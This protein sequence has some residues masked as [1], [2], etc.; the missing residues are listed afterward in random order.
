MSETRSRVLLADDHPMVLEGLRK[1]L[2]PDFE[3]V[4]VVTD[5]HELIETAERLQP[6]LVITDIS[7]PGLD[8][9]E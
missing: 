4:A 8:G 7:M 1:L 2:E 9:L 3:V 5:G 6:D